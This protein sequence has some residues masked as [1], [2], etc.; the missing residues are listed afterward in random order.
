M[1]SK[2]A[3]AKIWTNKPWQK[4]RMVT[5]LWKFLMV[6]KNSDPIVRNKNERR[7]HIAF[8]FESEKKKKVWEYGVVFY[9]GSRWAFLFVRF[10]NVQK[11]LRSLSA[12]KW[13]WAHLLLYVPVWA[14]CRWWRVL[15]RCSM[16]TS[17]NAV[18]MGQLSNGTTNRYR[19]RM[20][21]QF[22]K[23]YNCQ[24][25]RREHQLHV[26]YWLTGPQTYVVCAISVL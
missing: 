18:Q 8:S 26:W 10:V 6:L 25:C 1:F 2:F 22:V 9:N 20:S 23:T 15:K 12:W 21:T 14:F 5:F 17:S 13:K 4:K 19:R 7:R 16:A 3:D 24:L 11:I